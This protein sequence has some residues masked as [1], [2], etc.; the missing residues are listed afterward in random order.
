MKTEEVV[1]RRLQPRCIA[2]VRSTTTTP[3]YMKAAK[4]LTVHT[5][6]LHRSGAETR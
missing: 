3:K 5:V 2:L 1:G 6:H 4:A